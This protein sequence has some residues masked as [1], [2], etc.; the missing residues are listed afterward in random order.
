MAG[1]TQDASDPWA[2]R[3]T[4]VLTHVIRAISAHWLLMANVALLL[5]IG[6]PVLAPVL[7]AAGHERAAGLLYTIFKPLCHQLPERSFFL[8]GEQAVYS[9][10][11]LAH[12]HAGAEVPL[13]YVGA[14]DVGYKMAVC[15]RDVALY[16]AMLLGGIAFNWLR[17]RVKPLSI[18][19]FALLA[20]PMA[21]D[22]S[23]QLVG[24]WTSTWPSRLVTGALFGLACVWLAY[25]YLQ[26][27]MSEIRSESA[28]TLRTWE[29]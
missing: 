3:I 13:R 6:L 27:G 2:R 5:Y 18:K 9:L 19:Q 11:E 20:L 28:S 17:E 7:M 25:P 24:L 4:F 14:P 15:Q 26:R 23:G 12:I 16:G 1:I 21:V 22:G 10:D 29:S 8:F